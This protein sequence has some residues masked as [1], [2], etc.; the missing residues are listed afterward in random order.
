MPASSR[1]RCCLILKYFINGGTGVAE[2]AGD[3]RCTSPF[4][5]KCQHTVPVDGT[6]AAKADA[7]QL[8]LLNA[9]VLWNTIY[10]QAALDHLRAKGETPNEEDIARLSPL[11]HRHINMLGHYSFTLAVLVTKGHLRPLKEASKAENVA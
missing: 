2:L 5:V 4:T 1:L 7:F 9:V 3:I 6:P 10:M 11:W 8:C